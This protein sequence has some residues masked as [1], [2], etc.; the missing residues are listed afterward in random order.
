MKRIFYYG[1]KSLTPALFSLSMLLII[2]SFIT[3]ESLGKL[4][5]VAAILI[6]IWIGKTQMELKLKTTSRKLVYGKQNHLTPL[7]NDIALSFKSDCKIPLK[8]DDNPKSQDL[9]FK[10]LALKQ[11]INDKKHTKIHPKQFT[12]H[13]IEVAQLESNDSYSIA[14]KAISLN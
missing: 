10:H 6:L 9:N 11:D 3:E 5:V 14:K 7:E 8:A 1:Q 12:K 13:G 4:A 2:A